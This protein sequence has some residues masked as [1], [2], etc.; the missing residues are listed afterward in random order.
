[1]LVK[2]NLD[3]DQPESTSAEELADLLFEIGRS[4]GKKL[5]WSDAM[6][7]LEKAHDILS[8]QNLELLSSDVGELQISIMHSMARALIN[9]EGGENLEKAWNIIRELDIDCGDRLV[10]SLL[11]LDAF[12]LDPA[13]S[14]Q[15]YSDVLQ[16]IVRT[17]HFTDTNVKTILH[18]VHILRVRSPSN[19]HAVL[20]AL[21]CNRLLRADEPRW[22][23][24]VLITIIWNCTTS[25]DFEDGL[26]SLSEVFDTM[27]AESSNHLSPPATHAAQIVCDEPNVPNSR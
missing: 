24:K 21:L 19:A 10:V 9:M 7:W 17:V 16:R 27:A 25:T 2:I 1:M 11:K 14:A 5:Q 8:G 13:H 26:N 20:V 18:H 4:L 23:E 22:L 6:H 15:D 12:A 3:K